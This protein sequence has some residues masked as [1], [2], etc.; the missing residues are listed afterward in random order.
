MLSEF[1]DAWIAGKR[2]E[3]EDYLERVTEDE[4]DS[5]SESLISFLAFAPTPEYTD[6][7]L[8]AIRADPIVLAAE[9]SAVGSGSLLAALLTRVRERLAMSTADVAHE[10]VALLGLPPAGETKT[11]DYL[12]RLERGEL[13]PSRVSSRVFDALGRLFRMPRDELEG[14]ADSGG[15]LREPRFAAAA[16]VFRA[17]EDAAASVAD[18]LELLADAVEAP[19]RGARDEIDNLFLGGR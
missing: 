16:P 13:E 10:L 6:Q 9:A 18:D 15:F 1:I 11:A 4:R 17:D 19:G 12:D 3:V 14:A 8:D 7:D 5:L 2:P